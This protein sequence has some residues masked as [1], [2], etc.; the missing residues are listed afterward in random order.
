MCEREGVYARERLLSNVSR[1]S[2]TSEEQ[3]FVV[4][5]LDGALLY[6]GSMTRRY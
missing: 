2:V 5:V 6:V 4:C 1:V 3:Q